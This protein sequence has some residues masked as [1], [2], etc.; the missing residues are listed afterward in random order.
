[1]QLRPLRFLC[2]AS[3]TIA[4]LVMPLSLVDDGPSLC[5]IKAVSGHECPGCGMTRALVH[6]LHGDLAG[7]WE[8]NWR[9]IIVGP[10]LVYVAARWICAPG[11][12]RPASSRQQAPS[13]IF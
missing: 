6:A 10:L 9:W 5:L 7:A 13:P 2:L 11:R 1:M 3:I 12:G 4:V 8:F